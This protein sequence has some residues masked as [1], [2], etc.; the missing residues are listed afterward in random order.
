MKKII[1]LICILIMG[2]A[3]FAAEKLDLSKIPEPKLVAEYKFNSPISDAVFYENGK[4]K[5]VATEAFIKFYNPDGSIRKE[6]KTKD[7]KHREGSRLVD[8]RETANISKN[9]EYVA[10]MHNVKM[11]VGWVKYLDRN[12]KI[13][14]EKEFGLGD[15][16]VAPKG[17]YLVFS[18]PYETNFINANGKTM[19][20]Y[21]RHSIDKVVF[22][23][24]GQYCL[25][26]GQSDT[27]SK[28]ALMLFTDM[29]KQ[30]IL[31]YEMP[32]KIGSIVMNDDGSY[33]ATEGG[34][35]GSGKNV[36]Y[37]FS[38]KGLQWK[39]DGT[40]QEI[41]FIGN[42]KLIT[43]SHA[44]GFDDKCEVLSLK[45]EK[46]LE[47]SPIMFEPLDKGHVFV[48]AIFKPLIF[49]NGEMIAYSVF[50]G[51]S[52]ARW[53]DYLV[54]KDINSKRLKVKKYEFT[55]QNPFRSDFGETDNDVFWAGSLLV[56]KGERNIKVFN[57]W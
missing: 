53:F 14:F 21:K 20:S 2:R 40:G 41:E 26:S 6:I 35:M 27:S 7:I 54:I 29:G 17:D 32:S 38:Q 10:V 19:A 24:N 57:I 3:I 15:F 13:L 22:S 37:L 11:G 1:L 45:G 43:L 56:V 42:D 5:V 12:G 9:G 39:M 23:Q 47:F 34:A 36:L 33:F 49:N 46:L 4:P 44:N 55:F 8:S 51:K 50:S 28:Q 48:S 31:K 30:Q 18:D 52:E 25:A 16:W